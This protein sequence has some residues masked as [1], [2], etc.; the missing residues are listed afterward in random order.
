MSEQGTTKDLAGGRYAMEGP[1]M[2]LRFIVKGEH[3][4]LQQMWQVRTYGA[5]GQPMFE[6]EEWRD[7]PLDATV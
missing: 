5:D 4:V 3:R 1:T 7:V 2:R 6:R